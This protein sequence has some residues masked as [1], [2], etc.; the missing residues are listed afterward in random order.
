MGAFTFYRM[1]VSTIKGIL[2]MVAKG[3]AV[4]AGLV[5]FFSPVTTWY[6]FVICIS[7]FALALVCSL[8][9]NWLEENEQSKSTRID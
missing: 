4:I 5:F 2:G 3:L 6:G 1:T 8:L 9:G 7:A